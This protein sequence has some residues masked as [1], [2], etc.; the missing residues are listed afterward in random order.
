VISVLEN[1]SYSTASLVYNLTKLYNSDTTKISSLLGG[2]N[3]DYTSAKIKTLTFNESVGTNRGCVKKSENSPGQLT[4]LFGEAECQPSTPITTNTGIPN[5][6]SSD[7]QP[8]ASN[9]DNSSMT[10]IPYL[11]VF[12]IVALVGVIVALTI[13]LVKPLRKLVFPNEEKTKQK[14]KRRK[15]TEKQLKVDGG[16]KSNSRRNNKS[17]DRS[18]SDNS[19]N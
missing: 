15:Q 10:M 7:Q 14:M 16:S 6:N 4:F 17:L 19:S 11:L 13:M 1:G 12:S 5:T 8:L 2:A 3:I 9:P 18:K